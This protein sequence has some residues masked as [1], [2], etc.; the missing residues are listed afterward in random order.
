M[1]PSAPKHRASVSESPLLVPLAKSKKL[2]ALRHSS[3]PPDVQKPAPSPRVPHGRGLHDS[4][5]AAKIQVDARIAEI[6]AAYPQGK[7]QKLFALRYGTPE[8]LRQMP[9]AAVFA[10]LQIAKPAQFSH[11]AH[12]NYWGEDTASPD[13]G[14]G[15]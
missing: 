12:L 14:K 3:Q 11:I 1:T 9:F 4:M 6:I 7:Q 13:S 2:A 10:R 5:A 8:S 15:G